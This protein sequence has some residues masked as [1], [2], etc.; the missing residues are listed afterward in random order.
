MSVYDITPQ[1]LFKG[2]IDADYKEVLKEVHNTNFCISTVARMIANEKYDGN[3][4]IQKEELKKCL[5]ENNLMG[6]KLLK[7]MNENIK[8]HFISKPYYGEILY[9][10]II[11]YL[12]EL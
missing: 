4:K 9:I 2:F 11:Q 8:N 10:Q 1:Y 7:Y 12:L 3:Y 5:T 6:K